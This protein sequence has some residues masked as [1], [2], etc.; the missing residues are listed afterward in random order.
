[1]SRHVLSPLNFYLPDTTRL[2]RHAVLNISRKKRS[3]LDPAAQLFFD[4]LCTTNLRKVE[5]HE[6]NL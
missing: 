5:A 1:M 4:L 3:T 2:A 6:F